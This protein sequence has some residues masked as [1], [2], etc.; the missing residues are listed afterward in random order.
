MT[1][2]S[3]KGCKDCLPD[4]KR[5]APY[6]GPRCF[7]H[8]IAKKRSNAARAHERTIIAMFGLA[9]GEYAR[10]YAAQGGRCY[11]CEWATG[12]TKRLAVDHNHKTGE[13]RG[14]LCGPCNEMLGR[15]RD[16]PVRFLRGYE[17]LTNPPARRVLAVST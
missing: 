7:T 13:V 15:F 9:P 3:E 14:L 8:H 10:L 11:I 16:N 4:S 6:P 1:L 2:H 17:Y 12:K 5:P